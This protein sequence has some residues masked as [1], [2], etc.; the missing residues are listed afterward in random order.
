M[1]G[2]FLFSAISSV[3]GGHSSFD[4]LRMNNRPLRGIGNAPTITLPLMGGDFLF[5]AI[6]SVGGRLFILRQAQ[7]E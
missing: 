7:D 6:S 3:G 5:S 1:G 2:D 4:K